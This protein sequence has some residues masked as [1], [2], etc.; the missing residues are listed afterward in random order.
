MKIS[1]KLGIVF[2]FVFANLFILGDFAYA[3]SPSRSE[4]FA[5]IQWIQQQIII[6]QQQLAQITAG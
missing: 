4:L 2:I 3:A 5:K 1:V 6:L